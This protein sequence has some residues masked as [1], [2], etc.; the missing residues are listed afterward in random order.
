EHAAHLGLNQYKKEKLAEVRDMRNKVF[1]AIPLAIF[2]ALVMGW[3]ILAQY[4]VVSEMSYVIKEFF[5]HL[6]PIFA[7]YTLFV[8]GKPYLLG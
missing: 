1:S 6:L 4:G 2:A 5:H 8:V 3:D 7:T